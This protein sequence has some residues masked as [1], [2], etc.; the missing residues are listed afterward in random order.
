[1]PP[2]LDH[3]FVLAAAVALLP[4]AI[5]W[6][7][8]RALLRRLD[9]A[10]MPE[11]LQVHQ[12]R[13]GVA[14]FLALPVL[15]MLAPRS[16]VWAVPLLLS[17]L[18]LAGYR[19]RRA[20]Y[21]ETW[22][23][24]AYLSFFFRLYIAIFGFWL[25]LA[26][27][28][29][30]ASLAGPFDWLA[31]AAL[32]GVLFVW[33]RRYAATVRACLR[34]APLGEGPV[35]M[36]CRALAETCGQ[37]CPDYVRVD[38]GGG[39]VANALALPSLRGNAVLFTSTL[40]ERLNEN[41]VAAIC[42]H[43]LAH[44]EHF[45]PERLRRIHAVN[46]TLIAVAALVSPL[47]RISGIADSVLP[48]LVFP[49]AL[50]ISLAAR[51]RDKQRQETICDQRAVELT[52]DADALVSALTK[53]YA[54]ARLPRRLEN[55][56][57]QASSHPSLARRI[58]D[59]R[60]AAGAAAVPLEDP[61][62]VANRD[63]SAT[64]TFDKD[65][66]HWV[67]QA[68]VTQVLS[69]AHLVELRLELQGRRGPRLRASTDGTRLWEMAIAPA[70]VPRVQAL[71]DRVDGQLGD[72]PAPRGL[73][74]NLGR[75]FVLFTSVLALTLGHL[76]VAMVTVL[77]WLAPATPLL[78]AAGVA[79]LAAAAVAVRD[80][81]GS[82]T[83]SLAVVVA[84]AGVVLLW[85]GRGAR[86]D[87]TR[88]PRWYV[89]AIA[90]LA[91]VSLTLLGIN[92][93]DPIDLHQA[94]RATPSAIVLW[95]ALAAA[96]ACGSTSR[97]KM[98]GL[99]AAT[100]AI[101]AAAIGSAAFLDR[102]GDDPF[103]V[104]SRELHW[105]VVRS[106]QVES[107]DIGAA[108]SRIYLSP[109]AR[110]VAVLQ[111]TE[112]VEESPTYLVGTL[113]ESL[114]AL[115]AEH[116][117]F[118]DEQHLL[119]MDEDDR[120]TTLRLVSLDPPHRE[121]WRQQV[122]RL[123]RASLSLV[124]AS[125]QW[126]LT[127]FDDDNAIVRIDGT[128]GETDRQER[129]WPAR[130]T[131]DALIDAVTADGPNPLVV[132]SWYGRGAFERLPTSA[133]MLG[134]MLSAGNLQSRYWSVADTGVTQLGVSRLG[135]SCSGGMI[136]F[137]LVCTVFDGTRTRIVR[138]SAD[139]GEVTGVGWMNAR[140]IGDG[141]VVNGWLTGWVSATA[142]A[143]DLTRGEVLRLPRS[144]GF[145]SHL[146]VAGGRLAAVVCDRGPC[147]LRVYEIGETD[148]RLASVISSASRPPVRQSLPASSERHSVRGGSPHR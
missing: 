91:V 142:V 96:L 26:F 4:G 43:E 66:L 107:I 110:R 62:T 81:P 148:G 75:L 97:A 130:Y 57:E 71:L 147:R 39:A 20:L 27:L 143:I 113:G 115:S 45:T 60:K 137:A 51:A 136:D 105:T 120:G 94:A 129:R 123:R 17:A 7:S 114:S 1:M 8:G 145:A 14:T 25:L 47:A 126:R 19:L 56:Q 64:V 104:N 52:G 48:S 31:G 101:A 89:A 138:L 102:F 12:R 24:P 2:F 83:V 98:A 21:G 116:V 54:F 35:L 70:D 134:V 103:L 122:P 139:T 128:V 141:A 36:R 133:W 140:F 46:L 5:S 78:A 58:R 49:G 34:A 11:R 124:R 74:A 112:S 127:G 53:I 121:V 135:A 61:V 146:S 23:R 55:R 93:F 117:Q 38:L 42:A 77:A 132:E 30:L 80:D 10:A 13:N 68:G 28:P 59:I 63:G 18:L 40:L 6:A 95:L 50:L 22:T 92:G 41:E 100:V 144:E 106:A 3:P 85:V 15:G 119:T 99:A 86:H 109:G 73:P 33:E 29:M 76:A 37:P 79:T 9:D 69:Y 32:A 67:E 131:R 44:F 118:L 82:V 87:T 125:G 84:A 65:S 90:V 111:Q 72:L 88:D 16:F 108:S